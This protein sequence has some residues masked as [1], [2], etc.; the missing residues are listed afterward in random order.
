MQETNSGRL[1]GAVFAV[2]GALFFAGSVQLDLGSWQDLG[3][4][5]WP[6]ICSLALI[7][8]GLVLVVRR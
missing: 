4:G 6:L 7:F 3:P 1:T 8:I 5:M 2:V